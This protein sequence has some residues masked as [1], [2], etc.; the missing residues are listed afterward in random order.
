MELLIK[1]GFVYDPINGVNGEKMDITVKDGKI[2]ETANERKAKKID[3][4]GMIVMPGGVD[5]HCH[6]A[7]SEVNTGRLLRPEDHFKDFE[8]KTLITRSGVGHSIPSTFTTGYRYARMGYTTIMNPSMPPLEAKHT[9]EELNDTPM[10]DK[11]TYPLLGDWWFVLEY[12][13]EGKIEEC[14]RYVAWMITS[15]KGYAIKI[16]NP[17]G[18]EAWG[19]GHN[20][21]SLDDQV[22][23]FGVTPR[24]IIRGLCKVNKLLNLPHTIHVHTNNLGKPGNYLTALDTMKCVEDLAAENKPVIHITHCQFSAFKGSDWRTMESGAEEIARYVNNHSHAT[25][26]MGQVIFTDTTTMTADGPFQYTLHELSGNKWVNHDVE[27]ETSSGIVPFRYR[28]KS[29][30]HAIQWSIGLELALLIRD[31]WK[32]FMTTDHPNGGPFTSYPRI[33][34]WLMS[35]KARE[36]TLKKINP[37]A[38]SRSLLPSI[39]RE[40]SFYEL[41]IMTRAGQA[42][43]LGLKSKGHLG[44]GA[45][46][47]IA[48]YNVNPE[49][50]DPSRK[51]KTVRKAFKKAAYTIKGGE[52]VAR[53]GEILR[54]VEGA[55]MWLDVQASNPIKITDEMKRRFRE[56]WT[57]EYD[58]YPVTKNYLE[59]SHPI[60]VKA[61]V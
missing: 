54:H 39:D 32:I 25:L 36:A 28:R 14:A 35:R 7:G 17:G 43:A 6:I 46:A 55:T 51:Y 8:R 9:H 11:A 52:I 44:I 2:V 26:D 30:V 4:S 58:N 53:N 48:V 5:I 3:A 61:D 34:A 49:T 22:P 57:V 47:D 13:K 16:V 20:V 24:E 18:L 23:Y 31:L 50:T 12:L 15:T 59:V 42:K 19:F 45:D 60:T 37:R 40:L 10:V 33:I 38:R 21:N 29:Y 27:T 1:N 41:A 56:Y